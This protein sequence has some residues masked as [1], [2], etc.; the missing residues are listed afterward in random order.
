MAEIY[1][2]STLMWNGSLE[3]MFSFIYRNGLDGMELWAQHWFEK[4][5]SIEEFER[6]SALYP[7]KVVVHSCSWDLNPSSLN[8]GI[9]KASVAQIQKS[10]D[11][12]AALQA[13]EVTVHPGH[14]TILDEMDGYYERM[15]QSLK[16]ILQ[17]AQKKKIA[18]SLEIMEE[19]PKEYATSVSEMKKITQE[20]GNQFWYTLDIAH[21]EG[22]KEIFTALEQER[23]FSKF[24]ISNRQGKHLHVPLPDGDYDFMKLLPELEKYRIPFV[25][26]G[27]DS[28]RDFLIARKNIHFLKN[29]GGQHEEEVNCS[30]DGSNDGG[31]WGYRVRQ[32]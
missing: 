7:V 18:I 27:F 8:E 17:Y 30:N 32:Q 29:Y 22:E 25:V 6:L 15:H 23:R 21:C 16:E 4:G 24:H 14:A 28:S 12:A 13:D 31:N 2:C 1:L 9:R 3:D 10:I 20:M 19:L 11:L 26:E 5:Y